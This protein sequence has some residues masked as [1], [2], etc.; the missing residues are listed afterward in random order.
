VAEGADQDEIRDQ[1]PR[2]DP[3]QIED[4]DALLS[5]R[6]RCHG[7]SLEKYGRRS[8]GSQVVRPKSTTNDQFVA[9]ADVAVRAV[10]IG[11]S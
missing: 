11:L 2:T 8:A 5:S 9:N 3:D 1:Q 10:P 6:P 4:P 7:E